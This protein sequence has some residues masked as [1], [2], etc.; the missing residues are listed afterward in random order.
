MSDQP[1]EVEGVLL[2]SADDQEGAGRDWC[3]CSLK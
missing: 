2:V 1:R 3:V